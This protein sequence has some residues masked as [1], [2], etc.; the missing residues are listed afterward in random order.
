MVTDFIADVAEDL[1]GLK[2]FF[3]SQEFFQN[4][5]HKK[6]ILKPILYVGVNMAIVTTVLIT[7]T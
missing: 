7:A 1:Q 6:F 5:S 4:L 2:N 3:N